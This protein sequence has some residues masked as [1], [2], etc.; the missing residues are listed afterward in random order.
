MTIPKKRGGRRIP[1]PG[2]RMGAPTLVR[3]PGTFQW[4]MALYST[5][6]QKDAIMDALPGNLVERAAL[7]LRMVQENSVGKA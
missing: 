3:P 4:V 5:Q 7:L 2:K 6:E 1:G